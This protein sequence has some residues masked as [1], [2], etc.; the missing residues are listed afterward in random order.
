M[1]A[2]RLLKKNKVL[3]PLP[4]SPLITELWSSKFSGQSISCLPAC[5]PHKHPILKNHVLS[6]SLLLTEFFPA[7][8]HK[9]LQF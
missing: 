5:K 7:L 4:T 9:E 3:L 1:E 8:R 2:G 6:T